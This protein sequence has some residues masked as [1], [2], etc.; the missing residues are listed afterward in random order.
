MA[1][2][3]RRRPTRATC[4]LRTRTTRPGSNATGPTGP[5]P[6]AP[7][8]SRRRVPATRDDASRAG[9]VRAVR[10]LTI[11]GHSRQ[12]VIGSCTHALAGTRGTTQ[13]RCHLSV[14]QSRSLNVRSTA[15]Y[16]LATKKALIDWIS[17]SRSSANASTN[18]CWPQTGLRPS[19]RFPPGGGAY[20]G[21]GAT[22]DGGAS[23][24]RA[25]WGSPRR[26]SVDTQRGAPLA[27]RLLGR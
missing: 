12:A 11:P 19:R 20:A 23:A 16:P 5:W 15:G 18:S 4:F 17:S 3:P 21:A 25:R 14:Q 26:I 9:V 8:R 27:G 13:I 2:Q 24:G 6:S 7:W 10:L 22:Q 1:A